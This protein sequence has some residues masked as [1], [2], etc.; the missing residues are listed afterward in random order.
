V[1]YDTLILNGRIIDG[2]GAPWYAADVGIV[3]GRISCIGRLHQA[4]AGQSIDA[5]GR[6]V[7]PGL[8]DIHTHSDL[9]LLVESR[10]ASSV[11]QGITTQIVGNCGVS[12]APTRDR[13][14]Y[15]GPLD[16]SMT[17][18][19][20][21][22][23]SSLGDYFQRL[24]AGGVGTNVASLVG[25]G[26][27][28]VAAMGYDDRPPTGAEMDRM[29]QLTAQ[30]M[31]DGALGLSSG[32]AYAPGPY[33]AL[34]E[35]IE[36]GRVTGSYGGLYTSHIR[37]QTESIAAAVG[38]VITVGEE[39]GITAHVSHMQPGSPKLGAT[40]DLLNTIDEAR[41]RGVDISC[42][43]IPYTV[44]STTLK[45]LLP[46]WACEGGDDALLDRLRDAAMREI[47]KDD[48]ITHGAESGGS[49]KRNLVK[50][51]SWDLIWLASAE[52]NAHLVGKSFR[53]IGQIR[54]QDPHDAVLD[55]LIEEN[56]RPWMLAE[57]VS[58]EDFRNIVRHVTGGVISDGFS[59]VP[60]G[61][62]AEGKH[63]PR[64][65]GAF[66]YFLRHFIR[67][68]RIL[69][70][71]EAI[72]KLT[73]YAAVRFGLKDRGF[74]REGACADLLV[75][76]PETIGE[77]ATF[78]HP[79]RYPEG[80]DTVLVNGELAVAGGE[81]QDALAGSILRGWGSQSRASHQ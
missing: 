53:E 67:D 9:T 1:K 42:D 69:T 72:H 48:T 34:E 11:A 27:I 52:A 3:A 62:L 26:N 37:N 81:L 10:A 44:G 25:H 5:S 59:L 61:V 7:T 31:E 21:C 65:Y 57:D 23:W 70:W 6:F 60:E 17:R 35:L 41:R 20:E 74:L 19:L 76:D 2:S 47:I 4:T 32:L 66:P 30:A 18:G 49:R 12:A 58:E 73:G 55:I 24:E 56:A 8:I 54:G 16:P 77:R 38:E 39:A 36:L 78:D 15:Y 51:G 29:K 14:I 43:A 40:A 68:Q 75:F 28:R 46:P 80:I 50:D 79:Y 33:A 22:D 64:S 71:E 13:E 63:H 45:S